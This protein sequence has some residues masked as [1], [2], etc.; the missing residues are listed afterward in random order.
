MALGEI[1]GGN[2]RA[3]YKLENENDSSGNG[4]TLTNNN[5][6][7]FTSGKFNNGA[8]FGS[9]GTNKGLT[10]TT[11]P[12]STTTI[13]PFHIIFSFKLNNTTSTNTNATVI[14]L[15]TDT[16]TTGG[17]NV[18]VR[19]SISAGNITMTAN[20][21]STIA[22]ASASVVFPVDSI[23]HVVFIRVYDI[24]SIGIT[25]DR[26]YNAAN[27][28]SG[29]DRSSIGGNVMSIGNNRGLT[30]SAWMTIDELIIDEDLYSLE[31]A[32]FNPKRGKYYTQYKGYF[33]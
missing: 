20:R 32:G 26:I 5:S 33:V 6:V 2:L 29:V 28:G 15:N 4:L 11:N 16:A 30:S 12:L 13:Y 25:V 23:N 17:L 8:N 24:M 18:F 27:I 22:N 21:Q 31:I 14:A 1:P 7:T 10:T 19:Y 3:Y 9:S